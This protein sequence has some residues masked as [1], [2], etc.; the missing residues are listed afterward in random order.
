MNG[1]GGTGLKAMIEA[2]R[3]GLN[4]ILV[5]KSKTSL[6]NCTASAMEAFKVSKEK[7][8]EKHF[9]ETLEAGRF[10]NNPSMDRTLVAR[11]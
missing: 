4:V 11:A 3:Q 10:L 1:Y 2:R 7:D 8:S 5:S 9:Q 6:A